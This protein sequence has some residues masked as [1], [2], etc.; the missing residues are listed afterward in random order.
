VAVAIA[1]PS[2]FIDVPRGQLHV[3]PPGTDGVTYL[4]PAV[5]LDVASDADSV[6]ILRYRF[7]TTG[8]DWRER[9]VIPAGKILDAFI[10]LAVVSEEEFPQAVVSFASQYGVLGICKH[11]KPKGHGP[12]MQLQDWDVIDAQLKAARSRVAVVTGWI[13]YEPIEAWRRYTRQ[14]RG[15]M[16]IIARLQLG[17]TG[18]A[19]DWEAVTAGDPP[20][21]EVP[22]KPTPRFTADDHMLGLPDFLPPA[23]TVDGAKRLWEERH[24]AGDA[25]NVWR[26][27]GQVEPRVLWS[28]NPYAR[29]YF[30]LGGLPGV[31][32]AWLMAAAQG[33]VYVCSGCGTPFALPEGK[34]RPAANKRK[35]C[36]TCGRAEQKRRAA[37][38][39]YA[40]KK[41]ER[42]S[43][44]SQVDSQA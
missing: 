1:H 37:R 16:G 39:W 7:D 44:D 36:E 38:T 14:L 19:E 21:P 5:R 33:P 34:N 11:Q 4:R 9:T 22:E 15:L 30:R 12:C 43:S 32:A 27:Y 13:N 2:S 8:T 10:R 40:R 31:L 42:S 17:A 35:W 18:L 3:P 24:S 29:S 41:A 6:P 28:D 23:G 25:I 20:W 26:L